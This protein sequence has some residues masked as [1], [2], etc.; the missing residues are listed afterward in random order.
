M[1]TLYIVRHAKCPEALPGMSD[2]DRPLG[3]QGLHDAAML[4][5]RM[6]ARKET[7]ELVVA[8]PAKRTITTA[9]FFSNALGDLPIHEERGIFQAAV[10]NLMSIINALPEELHRVMLVGHN[11]GVTELVDSLTDANLGHLVPCTVVRVDLEVAHWNEATK[12]T[13]TVGWW[14]SPKR[15]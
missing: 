14:D 4:A 8:S 5:Q 9:H 15:G 7:V 1:K 13:A 10:P 12:G 11:P 6:A 3:E 2:F